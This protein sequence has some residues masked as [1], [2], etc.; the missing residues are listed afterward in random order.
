MTS[1]SKD[2]LHSV[3][4][5]KIYY[6]KKWLW[7]ISIL[8][9]RCHTLNSRPFSIIFSTLYKRIGTYLNIVF[10]ICQKL[11]NRHFVGLVVC[12]IKLLCACKLRVCGVL[13]LIT[14]CRA[15]L[16][17]VNKESLWLRCE[18]LYLLL[19]RVYLEC[20]ADSSAVL[21]FACY[22]YCGCSYIFVAWI[23]NCVICAAFKRLAVV[24]YLYALRYIF[25]CVCLC[26]NAWDSWLCNVILCGGNIFAVW[27]CSIVYLFANVCVG[28]YTNIIFISCCQTAYGESIRLVCGKLFNCA[29][30]KISISDKFSLK[31]CCRAYLRTVY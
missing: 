27:P 13:H 3:L 18:L 19:G 15:F 8:L 16:R 14:C 28:T 5:A 26:R 4:S 2:Q 10:L 23:W 24:F 7:F 12:N 11:W 6:K 17:P 31:S 9:L 21:P 25:S 1:G 29:V 20:L 30:L 22:L